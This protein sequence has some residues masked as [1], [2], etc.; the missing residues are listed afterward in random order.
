MAHE[1]ER[2]VG[3]YQTLREVASGGMASVHLARE[4]VGDALPRLVAL[5][6]IHD[7]L[8]REP[9]YREGSDTR[10]AQELAACESDRWSLWS[11]LHRV[12]LLVPF[13]S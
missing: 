11:S 7:H 1:S 13:G 12:P 8:D 2:P 6:R 10:M 5:K 4:E 3:R 9:A